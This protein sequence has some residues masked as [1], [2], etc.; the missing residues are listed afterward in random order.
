VPPPLKF[1]QKYFSGNYYEKFGHFLGKNHVKFGTGRKD[2][3]RH[4]KLGYFDNFS[5]KNHVKFGH[6]VQFPYIFFGQNIMH[7][8][9][10]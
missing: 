8:K 7:P 1:R 6:F 9:V 3:H 4:V 10:D 2:G 5:G